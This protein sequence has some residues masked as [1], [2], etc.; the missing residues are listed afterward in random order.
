[1]RSGRPWAAC[2]ALNRS[3]ASS[4]DTNSTDADLGHRVDLRDQR[5]RPGPASRCSGCRRRPR[6][7]APTNDE[8][9]RAARSGGSKKPASSSS[10]RTIVSGRREAHQ[11]VAPEALPGP[12][13]RERDER[14]HALSPRGGRWP[15]VSSRMIR[16]SS[17]ATTRLRSAVTTSAS[18]VAIR[19]VTPSSLI[20]SSSWMIS[21]LMTRVEVPRGLVGDDDP[22]VVDERAGD[23]GPLLLAARELGRDLLRLRR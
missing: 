9:R 8:A 16:P 15:P 18:W 2:A 4:R 23:R 21:Q 19:I 20:R 6:P 1:M 3:S 10:I 5:C 11:R 14:D 13:E 12:A 22:R 7:S 17:S